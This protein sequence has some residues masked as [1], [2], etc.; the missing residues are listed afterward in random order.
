MADFEVL[1]LQFSVWRYKVVAIKGFFDCYK[2]V[3]CVF[4]VDKKALPNSKEWF[5][6]SF[7][8]DFD[9]G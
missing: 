3:L 4:C 5:I 7:E 9:V 6:L 2:Q 1:V 8:R